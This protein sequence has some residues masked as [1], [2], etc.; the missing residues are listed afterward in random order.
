MKTKVILAGI[1]ACIGITAQAQDAKV[2]E[3]KGKA[4]VQVFGNFHSGFG[5]NNND[6]GFELERSYVGYEY[7]LGDGLTVKGVM[8]I[9]KSSDVSDYHRMAYIKNAMVSWKNGNNTM[10]AGLISTT[11]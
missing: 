9:G 3:P 11:H 2:E 6:R 7:K 1:L 5:E 4:I 10:K 8:D